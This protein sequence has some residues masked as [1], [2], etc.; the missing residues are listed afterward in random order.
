MLANFI[1]RPD[2]APMSSISM[3]ASTTTNGQIRAQ[4]MVPKWPSWKYSPEIL[5]L[6][7][8]NVV[9]K[10]LIDLLWVYHLRILVDMVDYV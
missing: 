7:Q 5:G 10:R 8:D 1:S 9:F 6:I 2:Q 4:S 3:F